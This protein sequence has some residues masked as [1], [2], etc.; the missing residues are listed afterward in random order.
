M[1][2]EK[3]IKWNEAM[4]QGF[5][6]FKRI[7]TGFSFWK[8]IGKCKLHICSYCKVPLMSTLLNV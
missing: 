4:E 1:T 6:T 2:N 7:S 8:S 3:M 5:G